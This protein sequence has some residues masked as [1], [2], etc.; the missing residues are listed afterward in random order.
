MQYIQV[1]FIKTY[2]YNLHLHQ[3]NNNIR[4]KIMNIEQKIKLSTEQT[5]ISK[6]NYQTMLSIDNVHNIAK[7]KIC[8]KYC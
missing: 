5:P 2:T 6:K 8:R 1:K 4:N 3:L 7:N